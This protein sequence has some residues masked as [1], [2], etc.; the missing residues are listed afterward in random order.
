MTRCGQ[1]Q[2]PSS[3]PY[4]DAVHRSHQLVG[5]ETTG[6]LSQLDYV[7]VLRHFGEALRELQDNR[8]SYINFIIGIV[9]ATLLQLTQQTYY[10]NYWM[11]YLITAYH[12]VVS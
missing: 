7:L 10:T 3:A 11:F 4:S 9:F 5:V 8:H 12:S 1:F 2:F 6:V